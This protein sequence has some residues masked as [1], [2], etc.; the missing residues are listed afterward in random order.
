MDSK[1]I[2]RR[3]NAINRA[4][5]RKDAEEAHGLEDNLYHE[6]VRMVAE[7]YSDITP[8]LAAMAE[9]VLRSEKIEFPRWDS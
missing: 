3:L 5:A 8:L 6:F 1:M 7:E 4:R 9:Q 2:T